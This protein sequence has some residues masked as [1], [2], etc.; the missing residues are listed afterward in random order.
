MPF[1]T[2]FAIVAGVPGLYICVMNYVSICVSVRN[3]KRGVDRY[4]SPVPF[5]AGILMFA[6][7]AILLPKIIWALAFIAFATDHTYFSFIY[8]VFKGCFKK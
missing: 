3:R 5:A 2:I 1:F 8:A 7:A 6:S 4:V